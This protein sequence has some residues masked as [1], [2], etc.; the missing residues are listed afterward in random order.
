M[1][2]G[3]SLIPTSTGIYIGSNHS[4]INKTTVTLDS[5]KAYLVDSKV[6][7]SR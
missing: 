1:R 2:I 6:A 5:P 3:G 4:P 7:A